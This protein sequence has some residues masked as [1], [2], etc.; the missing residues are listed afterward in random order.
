VRSP[1]R[2]IAASIL[3]LE[4]LVLF[5]AAI[6]AKDLSGLSTATALIGGGALSVLCLV[7]AGLVRS[8]AGILVGW[9]VQAVMIATGVVVPMMYGIGVIFTALWVFGLA[10]G[11]KV[12][13][14]RAEAARRL[15]ARSGGG[16]NDPTDPGSDRSST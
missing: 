16:D 9:F 5:F 13:R 10:A 4:A 6:V 11:A 2:T 3:G 7:A 1:Q 12:E 14:E 15:A 8:R